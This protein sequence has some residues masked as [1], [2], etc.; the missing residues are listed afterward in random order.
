MYKSAKFFLNE[1]KYPLKYTDIY[2][3]IFLNEQIKRI[4]AV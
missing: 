2:I 3:L 4:K 1:Q